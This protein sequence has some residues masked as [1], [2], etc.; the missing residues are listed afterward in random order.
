MFIEKNPFRLNKLLDMTEKCSHCNLVYQMEPSF[1]YGAMYVNYAIA[2]AISVSVF[3]AMY[4]LGDGFKLST[5]LVAIIAS[6]IVF[7]PITFRLGR[8]IWINLFVK[9]N[10]QS[11]EKKN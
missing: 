11:T 2:V 8:M 5:Y 1:F 3:V 10:P 9:Y 7:S 6:M 4:V